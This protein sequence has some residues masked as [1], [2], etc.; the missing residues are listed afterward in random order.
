MSEEMKY[1]YLKNHPMLASLSEQ[2][3]AA[4]AA[5]AK[6]KTVYR[7]ELIGYGEAGYTKIHFL[8]KGK[9]KITDTSGME[10]ELVKDILTEP[11]IFTF[12]FTRKCILV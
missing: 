7:G 1:F 5:M 4:V 10:N 11:D 3:L 12:P 6:M 9:V 8:V 2:K